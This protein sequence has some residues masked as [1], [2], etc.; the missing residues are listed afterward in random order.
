MRKYLYAG[1]V[2]G[3]FLLLGAAPA[4][5]D[6]TAPDPAIGQ[7]TSSADG[8]LGPSGAVDLTGPLRDSRVLDVKPGTNT[9]DLTGAAGGLLDRTRG[10]GLPAAR[11]GLGQA[12]PAA[13]VVRS[14][15]PATAD[16]EALPG[17]LGGGNLSGLPIV[18]GLLG[19]GLPVVGG[20]GLPLNG[21]GGSLPLNGGGGSLPIG[22]RS[23][24]G[25]LPSD[26]P[27]LG[28][29]LG[30]LLPFAMP[31][32]APAFSGMPAGG[33]AVSNQST[34]QSAA[35]PAVKPAVKPAQKTKPAPDAATAG[36]ARLHEEPVDTEGDGRQFS[37]GRPVAGPDPDFK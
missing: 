32:T 5:A 22:G 36:D 13:D 31:Q 6:T 12:K 26:I 34:S 1:A 11:T 8:L 25:L 35:K 3:G 18:G 37:A 29:G 17:G 30:G 24:S 2:A 15:L 20:G 16:T 27:L 33:T 19:G 9:P 4:Y 23:E 28:G 14:A 7:N 10:G 21:S